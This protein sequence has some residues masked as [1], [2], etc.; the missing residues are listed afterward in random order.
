MA[1]T[2]PIS[3]MLTRIRNAGMARHVKLAIPASKIKVA[4]TEVLKSQGYIKN[5]KVMTDDIQD[6]LVVYLKYDSERRHVINEITRVSKP[7]C[8]CYV[9]YE[10]IPQVKNGLG[11]AIVSTSKGVL[12]DVAAREAQVGGELVCTVW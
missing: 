7:S 3:D 10:D 2:D 1:M 4:I 8:R 12:S 5:Y 11:C 6:S 9:G